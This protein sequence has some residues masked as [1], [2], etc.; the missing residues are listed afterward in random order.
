MPIPRRR[1]IICTVV[2]PAGV[3]S[4]GRPRAADKSA[5][6]AIPIDYA[7]DGGQSSCIGAER[8]ADFLSDECDTAQTQYGNQADEQTVFEQGSPLVVLAQTVDQ[9]QHVNYPLGRRAPVQI[10]FQRAGPA[11]RCRTRPSRVPA[12]VDLARPQM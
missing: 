3:M 5:H 12:C 11:L 4:Y 7:S 2:S 8:G 1:M 6:P 10:A 9:L